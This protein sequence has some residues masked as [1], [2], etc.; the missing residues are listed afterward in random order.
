[1]LLRWTLIQCYKTTFSHNGLYTTEYNVYNNCI[2][3]RIFRNLLIP[4]PQ[5][6][7]LLS[8]LSPS[9]LFPLPAI[10]SLQPTTAS[11]PIDISSDLRSPHV[12]TISSNSSPR[13]SDAFRHH[14]TS[15]VTDCSITLGSPSLGPC[16]SSPAVDSHPS[17][18]F[19]ARVSHPANLSHLV[20]AS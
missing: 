11:S 9:H 2:P 7:H 5:K 14:Q 18:V 20:I 8:S 4:I 10:M 6:L 1:M 17:G 13:V 16:L 12:I 15:Y 3:G 19:S